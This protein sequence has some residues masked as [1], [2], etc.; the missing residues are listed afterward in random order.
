MIYKA[1]KSQKES[2]H[3]GHH[4]ITTMQLIPLIINFSRYFIERMLSGQ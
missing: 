2:G 4:N 3:I 1:L